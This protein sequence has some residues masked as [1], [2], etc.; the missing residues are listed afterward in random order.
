MSHRRW[1]DLTNALDVVGGLAANSGP[2]PFPLDVLARLQ[3]MIDADSAAGYVETRLNGDQQRYELV[4]R[5]QPSWLFPALQQVGEQDPI[6]AHH[7]RDAVAP[8]AISDRMS[9]AEFHR[10]DIY[11][12]VCQPLGTAD[13]IRLY[14][15]APSGSAR[16]FFFDRSHRG[17]SA[18]TRNLLEALRP[19]LANA[20]RGHRD[21]LRASTKS[22]LTTREAMVMRCADA[23]ASNAEIARQM[24]VSEHTVRKHLENIYRKL[25]VHSR[26]AALA[27]LRHHPT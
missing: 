8:V 17:F 1:T 22:P 3:E 24:F 15:P 7:C 20:R 18:H 16:F 5:K 27:A 26:T 11:R 4:T 19:H 25:G 9:A 21:D 6:H 2:D 13:S 12:R 23:G 10:L 14:L